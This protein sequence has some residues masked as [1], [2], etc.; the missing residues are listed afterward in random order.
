MRA[1]AFV[2]MLAM[3]PWAW[4]ETRPEPVSVISTAFADTQSAACRLAFEQA[5][6]DARAQLGTGD[7]DRLELVSRTDERLGTTEDERFECQ[8]ET[9]WLERQALTAEQPQPDSIRE[10]PLRLGGLESI[11]GRYQADC[12]ASRRGEACRE[13]IETEAG[14]ALLNRLLQ[15]EGLSDD[16]LALESDGFEG[17]QTF[18]YDQSDLT[19][20]MDGTFYFIRVAPEQQDTDSTP[21]PEP[22][23][24]QGELTRAKPAKPGPMD[25]LDVTLFYV[26]DGNDSASEDELALSARRWGVGLWVDNRIGVSAF[27]GDERAGIADS[28]GNVHNAG[29]RYDIRGVGIGYRVFDNRSVTL[30]NMLHY[31]DAQPYSTANLD[32]G[33]AA[34]TSRSYEAEDYFQASVNLKTNNE[35]L[36]LGWML[37]WKLRDDVTQFDSLSG[38]WYVELQF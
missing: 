23:G 12:R 13:Q 17:S 22:T 9:F 33:C 14:E 15:R 8:V 3:T 26:W 7:T 11:E 18:D 30:E 36:N 31:V 5:E 28:R 21:A 16:E 29:D 20:T 35:G 32:P 37:T 34:C 27:W 6:D 2:L 38:G 24:T 19:L 10:D 4:S 25:N 1:T